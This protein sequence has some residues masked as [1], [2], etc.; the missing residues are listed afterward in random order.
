MFRKRDYLLSVLPIAFPCLLGIFAMHTNNISAAIWLRNI[1][2]ILLLGITTFLF[3]RYTR[4]DIKLNAKGTI[5]IAILLLLATFFEEGIEGVHR[6]VSISAVSLNV[7]MA[8]IPIAIFAIYHL[9]KSKELMFSVVGILSISLILFFQP[10]ASQ[11][12]GFAFAMLFC[13]FDKDNAKTTNTVSK[14][15]ISGALAVLTI[16]SWKFLDEIQP[17][18]YIEGILSMLGGVSSALYIIGMLA[19]LLI[20]V[21]LLMFPFQNIKGLSVCIAVYYW[22]I[23]FSTFWGNFPVPF[24]GYGLS[25]IIGYFIVLTFFMKCKVS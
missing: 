6:W 16:L 5:C 11:L 22:A 19:V 13:L 23:T 12:T 14:I 3:A 20:P 25:P 10:D 18:D 4:H 8:V 15:L 21:P 9:L 2:A 7:S 1:S 24:M 17:V